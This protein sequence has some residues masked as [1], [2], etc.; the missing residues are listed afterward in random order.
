MLN[1]TLPPALKTAFNN[2]EKTEIY[3][4]GNCIDGFAA[5]AVFWEHIPNATFKPV[6]YGKTPA[7][8]EGTE[9]IIFLDFTPDIE[10][11]NQYAPI[12]KDIMIL[13]HHI[14]K[15]PVLRE[16][17]LRWPHF[18]IVYS[19]DL[20]G[21][22]IAWQTINGIYEAEEIPHVI[23]LIGKRDLG[24]VNTREDRLYHEIF[25]LYLGDT[26]A[27]YEAFLPILRLTPSRFDKV[28]KP[29]AEVVGKTLAKNIEFFYK[30]IKLKKT[31][32]DIDGVE[33]II[34]TA[35]VSAP[36]YLGSEIAWRYLEDHLEADMLVNLTYT[37][38]VM[39]MSFRCR[40]GFNYANVASKFFN[41]GGHSSAAGGRFNGV[42]S[43]T[44][45]NNRINDKIYAEE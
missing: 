27:H 36:Y 17:V 19:Q 45:V 43:A 23:N 35:Y 18:K 15:V 24:L 28:I 31:R 16:V 29:Q 20:S 12:V 4:H 11:F 44:E 34:N 26:K 2:P 40:R 30:K 1:V 42:I 10:W 14:D 9:S 21:A 3:Y 8:E 39:G 33:K 32:L 25:C 7:P 5:A 41:G 22:M 13:D 38:E 37:D 6:N